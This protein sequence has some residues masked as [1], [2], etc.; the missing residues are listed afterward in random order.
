MRRWPRRGLVLAVAARTSGS[1]RSGRVR[2]LHAHASRDA[3]QDDRLLPG[4]LAHCE[5]GG[6]RYRKRITRRHMRQEVVFSVPGRRAAGVLRRLRPGQRRYRRLPRRHGQPVRE[7]RLVGARKDSGRPAVESLKRSRAAGRR[8]QAGLCRSASQPRQHTNA[9]ANRARYSC[10][11]WLPGQAERH[12]AQGTFPNAGPAHGPP[13]WSLNEGRVCSLDLDR[14]RGAVSIG[15]GVDN[16]VRAETDRMFAA[17]QAEAGGVNI[18]RHNREPTSIDHQTVI[19][20]NRD[21]LYSFA[22]VDISQGATVTVPGPRRSIRL[23]DG[24][25]PGPLHQPGLPRP[26]RVRPHR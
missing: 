25:Q 20:M 3:A 26:G 1:T 7:A 13:R 15:V 19:R 12:G 17:L 14:G 8:R 22:I 2:W 23:G 16:F 9:A 11:R 18:F 21:T 24:R 6:R 4:R 10:P 5:H